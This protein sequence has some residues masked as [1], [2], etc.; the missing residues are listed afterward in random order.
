MNRSQCGQILNII[1]NFEYIESDYILLIVIISLDCIH[2]LLGVKE[3]KSAIYYMCTSM[4]AKET[5]N[6]HPMKLWWYERAA[7]RGP[8]KTISYCTSKQ[9]R[10]FLKWK[11]QIVHL[12]V[13]NGASWVKS[14]VVRN[15][16]VQSMQMQ[17]FMKPNTIFA[18]I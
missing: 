9:F 5:N 18:S 11:L 15:E 8:A 1:K 4:C 2:Y 10:L 14:F 7:R 13:T 17:K 16:M 6:V 3:L 12:I